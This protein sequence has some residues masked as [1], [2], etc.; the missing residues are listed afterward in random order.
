[1]K[2]EEFDKRVSKKKE[3]YIV[4]GI[5]IDNQ[6]EKIIRE[7]VINEMIVE[8]EAKAKAEA[9]AERK[10]QDRLVASINEQHR[11][12]MKKYFRIQQQVEEEKKKKVEEEKKKKVEEDRKAR[13]RALASLQQRGPA[14]DWDK[15][16]EEHLQSIINRN[17]WC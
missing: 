1:M 16:N 14:R 8:A 12:F 13:D 7:K 10:R 6:V 9:E 11:L 3:L 5:P 15:E 2:N 17:E 4:S